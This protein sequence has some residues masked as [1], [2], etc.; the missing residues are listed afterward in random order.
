MGKNREYQGKKTQSEALEW[1]KKEDLVS[2]DWNL[3][4]TEPPHEYRYRGKPGVNF[5][6]ILQAPFLYESLFDSFSLVACK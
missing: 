6:N 3:S 2:A 1:T 4:G 5:I